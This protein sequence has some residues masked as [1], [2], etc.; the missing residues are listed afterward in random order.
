M[1]ESIIVAAVLWYILFKLYNWID[2]WG[3]KDNDN[4]M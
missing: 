4:E 1:I 2:F 3:R